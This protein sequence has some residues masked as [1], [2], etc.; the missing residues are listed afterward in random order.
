MKVIFRKF[1]TGEVIAL[2][3]EI[4]GDSDPMN[5]L[6]YMHVGQHGAASEFITDRTYPAREEEFLPLKK[7]LESI[8]YSLEV[9]KKFSRNDY[10]TR[11]REIMETLSRDFGL[12]KILKESLGDK[13]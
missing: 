1:K 9:R 7:E 10:E 2:F 8:G 5:C 4:P 11:K 12:Y 13:S 3:P 6:S